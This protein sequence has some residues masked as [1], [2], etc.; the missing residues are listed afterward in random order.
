MSFYLENFCVSSSTPRNKIFY[1]VR[2]T[3][4]QYCS[5]VVGRKCYADS[6]TNTIA[7]LLSLSLGSLAALAIS[8][9]VVADTFAFA[10]AVERGIVTFAAAFFALATLAAL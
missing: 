4:L 3:D 8:V 1:H 10:V 2:P 9:V 5:T 7:R 6:G